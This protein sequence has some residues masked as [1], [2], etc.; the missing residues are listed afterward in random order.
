MKVFHIESGLGNQMLD[1]ADMIASASC[2]K[3]E[4]YIETIIYELGE[5]QDGISMWNGY[6]LE[7]IFDL[8]L[9][10]V[11][12]LFH[13]RDWRE[14]REE[15]LK[16]EFWND[17]WTYS[18][19]ITTAF[20]KH[21]LDLIDRNPKVHNGRKV[22][23]VEI[24]FP[25][26]MAKQMY[27]RALKGRENNAA[28]PDRIY[29][30]SETDDFN[31]HFLRLMYKGNQIDRIEGQLRTAFRFPEYDE[32]NARFAQTLKKENSVAVHARRG[33]FLG[34]N[35]YCYKFGYFRRAL[36]L[37]RKKVSDPLF[38]FFCDPGSIQWCRENPHIFGLNFEKDR[39]VFADWNSGAESYRDMQLMADCRHNV[40]TNSSFGWW[41]AYLNHHPDKITISPDA[42]IN[43]THWM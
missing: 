16:S 41:G 35:A 1:Y 34:H 42:R 40:I 30:K 31:G 39:V 10:N 33:D 7:S 27:Y 21:G 24:K 4:Y 37:I 14:I 38:V 29:F 6:E 20:R 43:T 28:I 13:D 36:S 17:G 22:M 5:A 3:D 9:N 19:A 2:N 11:K 18:D 26:Y 12:S 25:K 32:K 23:P 15:V 8:H